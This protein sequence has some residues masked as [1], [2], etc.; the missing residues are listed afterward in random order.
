MTDARFLEEVEYRR[1]RLNGVSYNVFGDYATAIHYSP[2][3]SGGRKAQILDKIGTTPV[4][5]IGRVFAGSSVTEVTLPKTIRHI[6]EEA[7]FNCSQLRDL[8]LPRD[9]KFISERAFQNCTAL[10]QIEI[11]EGT[12]HIGASAFAGCTELQKVIIPASVVQIDEE[13]FCDCDNA[14]FICPRG[15]FSEEH[16]R[17]IGIPTQ[18]V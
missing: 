9:L 17:R 15:S 5:N 11:P 4:V 10:R 8:K 12:L 3:H 7:F 16:L 6:G 2:S 18:S 14:T 1:L 13:A